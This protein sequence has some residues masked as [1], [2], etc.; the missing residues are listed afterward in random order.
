MPLT[1]TFVADFTSFIKAA[2]DAT[3][4]TDELVVSAGKV[5]A[6]MDEMIEKGVEAAGKVGRAMDEGLSSAVDGIKKVGTQVAEFAKSTW[7]V[8]NSKELKAFASDVTQFASG[9]IKEFQESETATV[10]LAQAVKQL[11]LP[12]EIAQSYGAM[13]ESLQKVSTFSDDAITKSQTLFT[14]IGKIGPEAMESTL[15]ATMD[16]ATAMGTDLPEAA[17]LV[18]KAAASDGDSIGKL[19]KI[20]GDTVPEG[21]KFADVMKAINEKFGGR[22]AAD[23]ETSAGQMKNLKNQMSSVNELVGEVMADNLKTLLGLF[24]A[25]PEGMQTFALGLV[26]VGSQIA[27][28]VSSLTGLVS[29]LSTTGLGA[30][31][32]SAFTTILP[33]LGPVGL[34]AA[35][36]AAVYFAWKYWDDIVAWTKRAIDSIWGFLK[37]LWEGFKQ[38]VTIVDKFVASI[39][40]YLVGQLTRV[41]DY[42]L[43]L[44]GKVIGAFKGMYDAVVGNSYVPDMIDGIAHEFGRLDAVMVRP[45]F[46]SI[47]LINDKFQEFQAGGVGLGPVRHISDAFK[48]DPSGTRLVAKDAGPAW[49]ARTGW[50]NANVTVNMSGMLDSDDP[51]TRSRVSDLVSNAVM[52]GMRNGR[53]LGTS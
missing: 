10:G 53:L 12:P 16:L 17:M 36:V 13:A 33:F 38:T 18:A 41:I 34:I 52:Q 50:G 15:K 24:K 7:A 28:V 47:K 51:Q 5:G 21:A 30:G 8:L 1:A 4:S 29:L 9:Y 32:A 48:L 2:N 31:I 46:D 23:L 42:V 49:G 39:K 40:D 26:S 27:P 44:P 22:A 6:S 11:G 3:T 45:T 14:S 20:L 35:G 19:G 37:Y 25:M 43:G